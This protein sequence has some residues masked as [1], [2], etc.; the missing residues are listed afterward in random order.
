MNRLLVPLVTI[1][2]LVLP[3]ITF[4]QLS[5]A[6][7]SY[8]AE[9]IRRYETEAKAVTIIRDDWGVPH[10]YGKTD[11]ETVFGLMYVECQTDFSRVEKNY[12]EMLG[13]QAEAYGENYLYTDVMMRLVYDSAQAV[14]DYEKSPAWMHKL[15]DAFADGVNYY[16]YR[17]PE[18]KPLVLRRF[19]PWYA[20]MFTDGSVSA[21]S[22]GGVRL[23]EIRN[24]YSKNPVTG[25]TAA[26]KVSA[27][28][29]MV[30]ADRGI[31]APAVESQAGTGVLGGDGLGSDGLN[32]QPAVAGQD[33]EKGSNGFALAGFRTASEATELYIN[34]HVPFY[35]RMEV[36]LVSEEGL[37][38]YGAVT[39]GQFFIYQGFNA[40]CGWMHTSSYADVADLYE[41]RVSQGDKGWV[42]AYEGQ[43][44]PVTTK[45][46]TIFYKKDSGL[47]SLAVTGLYTHHGPVMASR[48]GKWLS[49]REYNRSLNAL[50]EAWQITK[51][52]TFEEYKKAMD[53]R[54]NTTNNTVYA[55]DQ[56]NI[57]YWHGNFMPKR[58]PTYDWSLPVDGSIAATEWKGLHE[59]DEIVHVYNPATGWIQNCNSTPYSLSGNSSPERNKYPAYMAP[60]GE[61][62]RALNA[63]RLLSGASEFTLDSLISKG[64]DRY[65]MAFDVLLPA[66]FEAYASA[67]DSTKRNLQEPISVLQ[68]WDRRSDTR[69]VATTLAVEWGTRMMQY[70]PR[71]RTSEEA[72]NAVGNIQAELEHST[73]A[74]KTGELSAVI[75]ELK[76][77]YGTWR[78]N[79]GDRCRYQRLTGKIVET[80]DDAKPSLAVGLAP[81]SFGALPSYVSRV[82]PDTKKRY[83]Y[84]G[85]SFIAAVEFGKKVRAKTIV[86]GGESSDPASPHFSDQA[87]MYLFG[88]F[89]DVLFYKEDVLKN[90]EK[91]Y[92]P[93]EE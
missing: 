70:M 3:V 20:L 61:N 76:K 89:K 36:Q 37:N 62:F 17:H 79:W 29:R 91:K 87:T 60:D 32:D 18:I 4:G 81:S 49:L 50:M 59:L 78:V 48:D 77:Q 22:L 12:L 28:E 67:P 74:Q 64:Y 65:L 2:G 85:N 51:A 90:V 68:R 86:T 14:A 31:L 71:P 33:E 56:G 93:G 34:P 53:L 82:M 45:P 38:V 92:Q 21:T 13:R 63:V 27:I 9:E 75:N 84:S 80:Y 39:W 43:K 25:V 15:L 69:S 83:G 47:Q 44:K 58:D 72:S 73:A 30:L 11:A 24:F 7:P 88:I 16:L 42:Y 66:L 35:F 46:F 40:H 54:A 1:A 23:D 41:E 26:H 19:Q 6:G 52:N 55:D 57:A 8:S 5:A 10:I